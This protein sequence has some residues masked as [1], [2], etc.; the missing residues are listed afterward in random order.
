M[1]RNKLL[2]KIEEL[3]PQ[4]EIVSINLSDGSIKYSDDII[5][6]RVISK[7]TGD[8]ELTRAYFVVK[9][10]EDLGYEK[11]DIELEKEYQAG[12]PRKI[13]PRIDIVVKDRRARKER[14]F[15]F[16]EVKSPD[17]YEHD[18]EYIHSQL[19][20][21]GKL[22]DKTSPISYLVYCTADIKESNIEGKNIIIDYIEHPD[23]DEWEEKGKLALDEL[24]KEYGEPRKVKFI[25]GVRDLDTKVPKF[26]FDLIRK[27]LHDVLW[28]GGGTNYNEVFVNLVKIFLAKIYDENNTD[29]GEAYTFQIEYKGKT[30]E[31]AEEVFRKINKLYLEGCKNYL[32][33]SDDELKNEGLNKR[34]ISP[35]KVRYV[36]EQL[37]E[38][39][40]IKN[41]VNN[42][43]LLGDFFESI[44]TEGF[45]QDKGQF[46]THGNIV[47]F[48]IYALGIDGFAI[49]H[50]NKHKSLPFICDPACGSGSMLTD[51]MKIITDT[52][53]RR[54]KSELSTSNDVRLFVQYK[55]PDVKENTWAWDYLYGVEINPDLALATKVNMVLHG[56]GSGNIF[57]KDALFPFE[58]YENKIKVSLLSKSKKIQNYSYSKELNEQFD[59]IISNPP[60]SIKLDNETK[61]LLPKTFKFADIGS[62]ENLFVERWYQLLKEGGMLGVVLPESVFDNA[63]SQY[64]RLFIYKYFKVKYLISLPSGK[65]GAFLPYTPIKTSLLFLQKKTKSEVKEYEKEW[66]ESTNKYNRLKRKVRKIT[67]EK[68]ENKELKE[69]LGKYLRSYFEK[70]KNIS[71]ETL[72]KKHKEDIKEID[73]N[74]DWWV[75]DEVSKKFDY[76]I[77]IAH[78]KFLGYH[79]TKN[80]EFKRENMLFSTDGKDKVIHDSKNPVK[81]LDFIRSKKDI[82]NRNMFYINFSDISR[83]ICLR[84]DH[85]FYRYL[86][87]E[88][89]KILSNYKK[90]P[91]FF[92]DVIVEIRNGKDVKRSF[93][94]VDANGS[95]IET[96]YKYLT[97]NNIRSDIF[98]LDE[99]IN[100]MSKKGDELKKYQFEKNDIIITRSGSVG[101]TKV[102]NLDNNEIIY[103]PS[104]YLIIIKVDEN[105]VIPEFIEYLLNSIVMRKYFDVFGTGKT[106]KN[107]SQIDVKRIPIPSFNK[108]EQEE[109]VKFFRNE[110]TRIKKS[111]RS[112]EKEI[113]KLNQKLEDAIPLKVLRSSLDI[114]F[115]ED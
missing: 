31:S 43:D 107:I 90:K 78:T 98:L 67:L 100:L 64:M 105:K 88:E 81:I 102:F 87:F 19:F 63:E 115:E 16:I 96:D 21:L 72:L 38:I 1:D 92:R 30:P 5:Q 53:K 97:V 59:F 47:R 73:K 14:T 17:K 68:S 101:I 80:R 75:F 2:E 20:E 85:R 54:R 109:M 6:H 36:V 34:N 70:D 83:S 94:S 42:N 108:K 50:V 56:D 22:E 39:S 111:I 46:F 113:I 32:G 103:I 84:L 114:E 23:Y 77:F 12:R 112:K 48:I 45:K 41:E 110:R 62:S 13:K 4:R 60:F 25:K 82:R 8:E 104:G 24:P 57:S 35:N 95:L 58:K 89:P 9:L 65:N 49:N 106:Q 28:G 7:I 93:Y 79:R 61:R 74:P 27:D 3:D 91:F 86:F 66:R 52:I 18:K 29:D 40:L 51:A 69:I 15:L 11:R 99:V 71:I 33:Q 26:R 44:V 55:M 10:V 76:K 37:Q